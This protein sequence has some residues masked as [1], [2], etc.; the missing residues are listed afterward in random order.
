MTSLQQV[1]FYQLVQ[2]S[3]KVERLE[4]SRK[5]KSQK[6]P[7]PLLVKELEMFTPS[8]YMVRLQEVEDKE[9]QQY[10]VRVEVLRLDREKSRSALIAIDSIRVFAGY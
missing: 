7:P 8:Q 5:E 1:N 9:V 3:M 4:T 2:A 10:L 6:E